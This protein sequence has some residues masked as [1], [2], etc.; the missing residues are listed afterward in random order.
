ML[1]TDFFCDSLHSR[2]PSLPPTNFENN[3]K[4]FMDNFAIGAAQLVTK[5]SWRVM[6]LGHCAR[7]NCGFDVAFISE[8]RIR[9]PEAKRHHASC[10]LDVISNIND[11][12]SDCSCPSN[13]PTSRSSSRPLAMGGGGGGGG[14]F[15]SA[16]FL[17]TCRVF[18]L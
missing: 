2:L 13:L 11:M 6:E 5:R 9:F 8:E 3:S 10:L 15:P 16:L 12:K 1:C 17:R 7:R 14:V 4:R 18:L